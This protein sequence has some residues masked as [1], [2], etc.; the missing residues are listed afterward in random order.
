MN[1]YEAQIELD[2]RQR[3]KDLEADLYSAKK[4]RVDFSQS[5]RTW[6]GSFVSLSESIRFFDV[7]KYILYLKRLYHIT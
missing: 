6:G 4:G 2:I 5:A 7:E 1:I 3:I